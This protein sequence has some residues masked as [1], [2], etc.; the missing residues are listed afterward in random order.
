[1]P[2]ESSVYPS[3]QHEVKW[4]ILLSTDWIDSSKIQTAVTQPAVT[5]WIHKMNSKALKITT[6]DCCPGEAMDRRSLV[7]IVSNSFS[8]WTIGIFLCS[9]IYLTGC[10]IEEKERKM[11]DAKLQRPY[12]NQTWT[13]VYVVCTLSCIFFDRPQNALLD[14]YLNLHGKD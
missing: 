14:A 10:W 13:C 4:Q 3:V 1:M 6:K 8:F 5:G 12:Q 9:L 2:N 7:S 11:E